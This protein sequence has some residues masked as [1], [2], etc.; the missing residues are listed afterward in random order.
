MHVQ[1]AYNKE[2]G[3]YIISEIISLNGVIL[4]ANSFT[5]TNN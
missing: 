2:H 3:K 5:V 4:N 1:E